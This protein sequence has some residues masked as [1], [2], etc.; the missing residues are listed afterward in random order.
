MLPSN[1]LPEHKFVVAFV[2]GKLFPLSG[3]VG[4]L[5]AT[6]HLQEAFLVWHVHASPRLELALTLFLQMPTK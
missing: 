4:L 2:V 3:E 5:P 6:V 1:R